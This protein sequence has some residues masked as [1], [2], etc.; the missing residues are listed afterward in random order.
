MRSY[1]PQT[2]FNKI[3]RHFVRDKNPRGYSKGDGCQ[4]RSNGNKCAVGIFIP[5]SE[6]SIGL[7]RKM[8]SE[9]GLF[10]DATEMFMYQ[11][12]DTHDTGSWF[13][14]ET[15][16]SIKDIKRR[17]SKRLLGPKELR[18]LAQEFNLTVPTN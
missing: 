11:A 4:Y 10:D 2:A 12:Q 18:K 8:I 14:S 15:W 6:Y 9:L 5:N 13:Q 17:Q 1:T 7:E 3:W 16:P